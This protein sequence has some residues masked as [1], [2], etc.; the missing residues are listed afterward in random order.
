MRTSNIACHTATVMMVIGKIQPNR[1]SAE[2]S[3]HLNMCNSTLFYTI[4]C[5]Q[6]F[7][8]YLKKVMDI[9]ELNLKWK[10]DVLMQ[11]KCLHINGEFD[12]RLSRK[13]WLLSF[14]AGNSWYSR[15]LEY[16]VNIISVWE[17]LEVSL[18]RVYASL[19]YLQLI[20]V[21]ANRNG[22]AN[23]IMYWIRKSTSAYKTIL[24][25]N[26]DNKWD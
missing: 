17:L 3:S 22:T 16:T 9:W 2:I 25:Y 14:D 23:L 7:C 18:V 4:K 21:N 8:N 15:C 24:I 13:Y 1:R 26:C 6:I 5:E 10:H 12:L 19:H 11:W 20:I